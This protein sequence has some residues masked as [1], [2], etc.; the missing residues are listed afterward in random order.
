[1]AFPS[2]DGTKKSLTIT[3]SSAKRLASGVSNTTT[4]IRA[5]AVAGILSRF[6]ILK[7][8]TRLTDALA[9]FAVYSSVSGIAD[10]AKEQEDDVNL[11][12]VAEFGAMVAAITAARDWIDS[13]FPAAGG[14]AQV[15]QITGGR[16]SDPG[17]TVPQLAA[18]VLLLDDVLASID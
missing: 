14:F 18:L 5:N 7:Y 17:F 8:M 12:I 13:N 10:Y 16:Y 2:S 1:M 6:E 9:E 3:Y 15:L 11:D 4:G